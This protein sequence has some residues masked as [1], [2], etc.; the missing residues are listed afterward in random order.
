MVNAKSNQ[1][2]ISCVVRLVLLT[3]LDDWLLVVKLLVFD[4]K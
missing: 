4:H 1:P 2:Y 3:L